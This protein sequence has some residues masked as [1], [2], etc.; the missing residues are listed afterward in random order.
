MG[1]S[2]RHQQSKSRLI[3][4]QIGSY[5]VA[6]PTVLVAEIVSFE[7]SRL[8]SLPMYAHQCMGI[9][10]HRGTL[11]PLY[12]LRADPAV[13]ESLP[14]T[15]TA[16]RLGAEAGKRAGVGIEIDKLLGQVSLLQGDKLTLAEE[17]EN[18]S[19]GSA[20]YRFQTSSPIGDGADTNT[21][22]AGAIAVGADNACTKTTE[23]RD[24]QSPLS[25]HVF[26][27]DDLPEQLWSPRRT[28]VSPPT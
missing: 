22:I 2:T 5:R 3:L 16:I 7:R 14:E 12:S 23:D 1:R 13:R 28:I 10:H 24:H 11:M 6:F 18:G 17:T 21:D 15:L 26:S 27:L 8:L 25:P 20:E 4:T 9:V 19:A